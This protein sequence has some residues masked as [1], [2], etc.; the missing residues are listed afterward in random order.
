M[1]RSWGTSQGKQCKLSISETLH[2]PLVPACFLSRHLN[3]IKVVKS[4]LE[5]HDILRVRV[6]PE[7]SL[8]S[9]HSQWIRRGSQQ[10]FA[11]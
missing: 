9:G 7:E 3:S 1:A 2:F 8:E 6:V 5:M 4:L 11:L 10:L